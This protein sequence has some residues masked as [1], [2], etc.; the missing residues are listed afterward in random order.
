MLL[1]L[2]S[3]WGLI[4]LSLLASSATAQ[5]HPKEPAT[6][7]VLPSL[8][9][10]ATIQD[11]WTAERIANIPSLLKK[12]DAQAW[13]ICHREHA[14]DTVWWS[15]KNATDF[16]TRRRTIMLFH[17]GREGLPNPIK[18]IDNTGQAW[19]ELRA[20]LDELSP[21]RIV[22][23]VD[24]NIAFSGG[25]HAGEL[26]VIERELGAQWMN[27]T[28]NE[29]MLAVEYV[30][31]R[32][33]GQKHYYRKMQEIA[34]ALVEEGFSEK[35]IVPGKTT[36]EDLSWWFREK[37][38][39]LNVTTWFQPSITVVNRVSF[40]GSPEGDKPIQEGDMLHI[41]YGI[42]AM[43]LNTDTQHLGY[44][45][46]TDDEQ[47]ETDATNSLKEGLRK[48]NR[49]QDIILAHMRPGQTGNEV[50]QK[51]LA[52]MKEE[53]IEGQIYC[54]PIGDW[55]HDAGA[56]MGFTN[57][58]TY[59]PVLGELPILANT[60]Y[61]IELFAYHFISERNETLRFAQE[62]DVAWSEESKSWSFVYGRQER[63]HLIDARKASKA[64]SPPVLFTDQT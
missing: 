24:E 4:E 45:L 64:A 10:R 37:M 18:W 26:A 56:V 1:S 49:M 40:P 20:T 25:L 23:N 6:Y 11:K 21:N 15:I 30:A 59:V 27:R 8:R 29:A 17:T 14:E 47:A 34:W 28:V 43:G 58:P 38:Q 52:Q 13:L 50:L 2:L 51:S 60:F 12:Y 53:G 36:T 9:E 32:V 54:H 61:S 62:E 35:V 42:T 33:P 39:S 57:L 7:Q 16:D 44:V 5:L 3:L 55:G 46:R 19:P 48:S 31:T 41:D 22:L 63:F